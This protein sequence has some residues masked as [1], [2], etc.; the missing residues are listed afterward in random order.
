MKK[1]KRFLAVI[2]T[3]VMATA[4]MAVSA[5]AADITIGG[6]SGITYSAYKL[7]DAAKNGDVKYYTVDSS[8]AVYRKLSDD[9]S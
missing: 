9:T 5:G 8:S 1:M 3:L 7:F 2:L 6:D 4:V